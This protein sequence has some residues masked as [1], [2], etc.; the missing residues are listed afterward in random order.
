MSLW[1]ASAIVVDK[2]RSLLLVPRAA[3]VRQEDTAADA[4]EDDAD[5]DDADDDDDDE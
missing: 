3:P 5:E 2:L 4:D 1:E